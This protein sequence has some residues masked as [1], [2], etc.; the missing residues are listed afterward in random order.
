M[1][2][3]KFT[4]WG[5]KRVGPPII[6]LRGYTHEDLFLRVHGNRIYLSRAASEAIGRPSAVSV[7]VDHESNC[8]WIRPSSTDGEPLVKGKHIDATNLI[9]TMNY[10]KGVY[11][12]WKFG[13]G[14][15]ANMNECHLKRRV[16]R[17]DKRAWA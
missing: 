2:F 7:F 5:R 1:S 9:F 11:T 8:M 17:A 10:A 12:C 16:W 3:E 6:R 15:V 14:I 13:D 4:A